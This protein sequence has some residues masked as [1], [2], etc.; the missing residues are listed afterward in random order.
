MLVP[1]TLKYDESKHYDQ[2]L[3]SNE[4]W[5]SL[6][7]SSNVCFSVVSPKLKFICFDTNRSL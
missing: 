3:K 4:T 1:I 2:K 7:N 6:M 5:V